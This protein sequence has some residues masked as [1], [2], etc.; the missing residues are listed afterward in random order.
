MKVKAPEHYLPSDR[1]LAKSLTDECDLSMLE[2][3]RELS[4]DKRLI[5]YRIDL[6]VHEASRHVDSEKIMGYLITGR[7]NI[8]VHRHNR[9][10]DFVS[11]ICS[12]AASHGLFECYAGDEPERFEDSEQ[13]VQ[14]I[15]RNETKPPVQ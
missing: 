1:V 7:Y 9:R 10:D 15:L 11:I 2:L 3:F 4:Y 13:V 12:P 8:R 14:Y 6:Q 5:K